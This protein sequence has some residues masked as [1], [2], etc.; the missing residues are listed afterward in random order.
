VTLEEALVLFRGPGIQALTMKSTSLTLDF[1]EI[2]SI[3][4]YYRVHAISGR[5]CLS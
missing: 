5:P 4:L 1:I 3:W 2:L